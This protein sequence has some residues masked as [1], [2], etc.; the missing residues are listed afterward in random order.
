MVKFFCD[1]NVLKL[2][3][4]LRFA[5]FDTMTR[6]ELSI[7]KIENVCQ[8]DKRI[9]ITRNKGIRNF[10]A[11]LEIISFENIDDQ[12]KYFLSKYPFQK[13]LFGSR[14]LKCNVILKI[15]AKQAPILSQNQMKYCPRCGKYFWQGSHYQNMTEF[16]EWKM[17]NG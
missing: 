1:T 15:S 8:K 2:A 6:R 5:G 16:L 12:L 10:R 7:S 4:W 11:S 9:F 17:D 13:D 14:C 3:K